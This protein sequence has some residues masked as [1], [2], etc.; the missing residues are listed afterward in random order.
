MMNACYV[1]AYIKQAK[2]MLLSKKA[3]LLKITNT[4]GNQL[5]T[6]AFKVM[7]KVIYARIMDSGLF[8]TGSYQAG[9]NEVG[10]AKQI[11]QSFLTGS[12]T[13]SEEGLRTGASQP[14]WTSVLLLIA[15][16]DQ[17]FVK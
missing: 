9:C 15:W 13:R 1:P 2:F 11:K 4:C 17:N 8:E 6:F 14:Y 5:L 7:E 10:R 3:V 16:T 12:T